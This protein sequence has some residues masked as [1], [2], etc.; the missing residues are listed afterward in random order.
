VFTTQGWRV[1]TLMDFQVVL[2]KG[3]RTNHLLHLLLSVVTFG[4][5]LAAWPAVAL[6]G[7]ERRIVLT[8]D[9]AGQLRLA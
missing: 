4:L 7:G 1:E 3:H 5:W 8:V 2:V 6:D 9:E